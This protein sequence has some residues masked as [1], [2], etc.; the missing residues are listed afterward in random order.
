MMISLDT[1]FTSCLL[2]FMDCPV[3]WK[4]LGERGLQFAPG[5]GECGPA[6]FS[7]FILPIWKYDG[8]KFCMTTEERKLQEYGYQCS[9]L[10]HEMYI[11][12]LNSR[13]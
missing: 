1:K 12:K 2:G 8:G 5:S 4:G 6:H 11:K 3:C 7:S 13:R 10:L 9:E